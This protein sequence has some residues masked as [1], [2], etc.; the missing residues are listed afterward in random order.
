[1]PLVKGLLRI[2]LEQN[3]M[4]LAHLPS[5]YIA[6][7]LLLKRIQNKGMSVPWL[8]F[9]GLFGS[10][11][12]DLDMFYFYL[13]DGRQHHHHTYWSHYPIVW[14]TLLLVALLYHRFA[15]PKEQVKSLYACVFLFMGCIH[16]LLDSIV[17]D[18]W[19][20][21]PF[22]DRPF[23]LAIVPARFEPWWLNF[24]LHGSFLLEIGIIAW[25]VYL[26]RN[27][28]NALPETA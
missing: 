12:P 7:K 9:W 18:V 10:I 4:F 13:I 25:A 21:M 8:F 20:L 15:A 23:A 17:G 28:R 16:L 11:A 27:S 24:I 19:W 3:F 1:M 22:I 6:V 5:G 26:W 14:F 2:F